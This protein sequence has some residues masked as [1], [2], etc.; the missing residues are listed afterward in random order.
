MGAGAV[1]MRTLPPVWARYRAGIPALASALGA[2][3]GDH[4][5]GDQFVEGEPRS[6]R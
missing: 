2:V 1:V 4:Q 6:G 5:F 3:G